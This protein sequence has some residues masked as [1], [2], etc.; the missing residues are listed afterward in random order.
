MPRIRMR[1]FWILGTVLTAI[2]LIAFLYMVILFINGKSSSPSS[3]PV[4][5]LD[6]GIVVAVIGFCS[7]TFSMFANAIT[8]YLSARELS[9][10]KAL[11]FEVVKERLAIYK[12]LWR[13]T[14]DYL[15]GRHGSAE[16]YMQDLRNEL[17][18]SNDL[19][20]CSRG[21]EDS[22][23]RLEGA[24]NQKDLMEFDKHVKEVKQVIE[25]ELRP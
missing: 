3:S 14:I 12:R 6:E 22:V 10:Q 9:P 15:E 11:D 8:S 13:L 18:E 17:I 5:S 2:S 16:T 19:L 25:R 20:L 24:Y 1:R 21:V 7:T 4:E 23:K